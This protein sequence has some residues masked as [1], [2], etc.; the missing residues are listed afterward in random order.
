M[1]ADSSVSYRLVGSGPAL[2]LVHG[3]GVSFNI[4]REIGPPL[5]EHF[6]LIL[7]ELPGIGDSDPPMPDGSYTGSCVAA[8][9]S[10]RQKVAIP[11]WSVLAY[12]IGAGV[13]AAYAS[14]HPERTEN[15]LLICPPILKGWRWRGLRSLLW[16]DS[17]QPAIGDWLLSGWRLYWLVALIGFNGRP[18]SLTREWVDEIAAQPRPVLKAV[19]REY[20]PGRAL[21]SIIGDGAL[22]LCGKQD[23]VSVRPPRN[24]PNVAYFAGDHSGP[25]RMAL[26][27]AAAVVRFLKR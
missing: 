12:S 22:L 20:P 10:V 8:I 5:A 3:F 9:E 15:S 2:L 13:A 14:A 18:D 4:W 21:L 16:L 11:K 1:T 6:C 19:L 27:I 24:R 7:V 26:P 25:V 17:R 23:F